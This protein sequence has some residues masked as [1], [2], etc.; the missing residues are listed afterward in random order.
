MPSTLRPISDDPALANLVQYTVGFLLEVPTAA[1]TSEWVP[2]GS[3]TFVTMA[4][5][6]GILTAGHVLYELEKDASRGFKLLL[7]HPIKGEATYVDAD[8]MVCNVTRIGGEDR[9]APN[10]PDIGFL[11]LPSLITEQLHNWNF[12]NLDQRLDEI[13]RNFTLPTSEIKIVVAGMPAALSAEVNRTEDVVTTR[14]NF[15]YAT[16]RYQ[17]LGF[18]SGELDVAILHINEDMGIPPL[19]NYGGMSGGGVSALTERGALADRLLLGVAFWQNDRSEANP[20]VTLRAHAPVS[21]YSK[22]MDLLRT[23]KAGLIH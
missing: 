22:L 16:G 14:H 23:Q 10:G 18:Q 21:I 6:K 4:G 13:E 15:V 11:E 20:E 8:L 12:H 5:R 1:A 9:N 7:V 19:K 17:Y 3:G 2:S